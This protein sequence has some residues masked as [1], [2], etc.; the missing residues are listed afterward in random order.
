MLLRSRIAICGAALRDIMGGPFARFELWRGH[1]SLATKV[2]R[3]RNTIVYSIG[4]VLVNSNQ[5]KT[6]VES[7]PRAHSPHLT[8][9]ATLKPGDHRETDC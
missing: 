1:G 5:N 7:L 6:V 3:G 8:L 9:H 4:C 2:R